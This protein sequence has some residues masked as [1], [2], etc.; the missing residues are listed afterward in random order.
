M[1][2][3]GVKVADRQTDVDGDLEAVLRAAR[4]I[5]GIVAESIAA[6]GDAVTMPQ[7]RALVLVATRAGIN[8]GGIATALDIHPSNATR[9]LDRLVQAGLLDRRDSPVDRRHVELTLT[10]EGMRLVEAVMA[11]RRSAFARVLQAMKPAD[12]RRLSR[13]LTVF[14]DAADEPYGHVFIPL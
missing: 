6:T 10:R 5:A 3:G 7:F 9:L 12:R 13:S 1:T 14:A 2:G 11:H 8:A 4:V